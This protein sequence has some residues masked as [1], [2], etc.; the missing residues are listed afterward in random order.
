M[1]EMVLYCIVLYS[2]ACF[3]MLVSHWLLM[4][5]LKYAPHNGQKGRGRRWWWEKADQ[6]T[7]WYLL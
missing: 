6:N 1:Q 5:P 7:V 4:R 3:T 2:A